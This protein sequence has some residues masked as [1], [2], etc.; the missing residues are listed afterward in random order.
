MR[1]SLLHFVSRVD[2]GATVRLTQVFGLVNA[3][4]TM[5]LKTHNTDRSIPAISDCHL[6]T[7]GQRHSDWVSEKPSIADRTTNVEWS[8]ASTR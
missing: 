1:L 4:P 2:G 3:S 7:L 5:S 6:V 8:L